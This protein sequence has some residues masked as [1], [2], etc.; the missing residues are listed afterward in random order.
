MKGPNTVPLL[1]AYRRYAYEDIRGVPC[2][3]VQRVVNPLET[4]AEGRENITL[5]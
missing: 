4:V 2:K 3:H 5:A 1:E